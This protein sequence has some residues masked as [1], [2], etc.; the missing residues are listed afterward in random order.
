MS[1]ED[2]RDRRD[3]IRLTTLVVCV[4]SIGPPHEHSP[5]PIRIRVFEAEVGGP[6]S[7]LGKWM[8][9]F[10]NMTSIIFC[11]AL[12][13]YDQTLPEEPNQVHPMCSIPRVEA[14]TIP[15]IE[16]LGGLSSCLSRS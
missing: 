11:T 9:N 3:G 15:S 16:S 14:L 12:S 8:D 5:A 7:E 1:T 2:Y 6:Q 4:I 10:G 13:E